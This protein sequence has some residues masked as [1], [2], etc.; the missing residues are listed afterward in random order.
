MPDSDS[1]GSEPRRGQ[2]GRRDALDPATLASIRDVIREERRM[3][4]RART[5]AITLESALRDYDELDGGDGDAVMIAIRRRW[6][7]HV[8]EMLQDVRTIAMR[9]HHA[10]EL[11]AENVSV[12]KSGTARFAAARRAFERHADLAESTARRAIGEG[13]PT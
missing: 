9:N 3:C 12:G 6:C 4:M 1:R 8:L 11:I 13:E 7:E 10:F 5:L 2:S